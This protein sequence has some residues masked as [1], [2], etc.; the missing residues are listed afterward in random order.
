VRLRD[1]S[2]L[3]IEM[4]WMDGYQGGKKPAKSEDH[5]YI[6]SVVI[7]RSYIGPLN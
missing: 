6:D 7:A 2:D 5:I 1:T 3:K 4:V